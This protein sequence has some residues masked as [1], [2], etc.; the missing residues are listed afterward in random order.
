M[1]NE[2]KYFN[3]LLLFGLLIEWC[4][5]GIS[6]AVFVENK[7]ILGAAL[8]GLVAWVAISMALLIPRIVADSFYKVLR[9][10]P[11]ILAI[12][13]GIISPIWAIFTY[14]GYAVVKVVKWS[15]SEIK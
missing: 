12:L 14:I 9:G 8:G 2:Q 13:A 5:I 10:K 6:L 15:K 11:H 4:V 7:Q 1:S 3:T